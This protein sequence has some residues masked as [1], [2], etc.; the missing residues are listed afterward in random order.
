MDKPIETGRCDGEL[1]RRATDGLEAPSLGR[2]EQML[3]TALRGPAAAEPAGAPTCVDRYEIRGL[4]G[5]GAASAVFRARDPLLDRDVALKLL[6]SVLFLGGSFQARFAREARIVAQLRHTHIVTV[7]DT[8]VLE[9]RPWLVMDLIEGTTLDEQ[10]GK[11]PRLPTDFRRIGLLILKVAEALHFAHLRGVVHRDVKPAN[12]LI[13]ARGEPQ[14]TDFGLAGSWELPTCAGSSSGLAPFTPGAGEASFSRLPGA[15]PN[16]SH[17]ERLTLTGQILGTPQ[18][19]SPEQADCRPHAVDARSDVFSLGVVTYELLT[20]QPPFAGDR[21]SLPRAIREADPVHPA[22]LNAVVPWD[23]TAIC[24]KALAKDPAERY[25]TAQA[26]ADEIRLWLDDRPL[27][28]TPTSRCERARRW[29]RRNLRF[30]N[31]G[32]AAAC[33]FVASLT[34]LGIAYLRHRDAKSAAMAREELSVRALI[35][36]SRDLLG[37]PVAG[38]VDLVSREL[39][40]RLVGHRRKLAGPV[41]VA[42]LDRDIRSLLPDLFSNTDLYSVAKITLRNSTP[43]VAWPAVLHPSGQS[44]AI[45]A[46]DRPYRIEPASGTFDLPLGAE[47]RVPLPRLSYCPGGRW[48]AFAPA[49]GGIELWDESVVE[50]LAARPAAEV[51]VVLAIGFSVD[52]QETR[53]PGRAP[54][55]ARSAKC[56]QLCCRD[57]TWRKFDV[58]NLDGDAQ[59][60]L[61]LE[62]WSEG[63][64]AAAFDRTGDRLAVG[65]ANG[66]IRVYD[67]AGRIGRQF[68]AGSDAIQALAWSADGKKIGAGT[69]GGVL[70]IHDGGSGDVEYRFLCAP[71]GVSHIAFSPDGRCV[72][73]GDRGMD[74]KV[75]ELPTG[76]LVVESDSTPVAFAEDS[77]RLL[78]ANS[79]QIAFWD[80]Y[81][82]QTV[83]RLTGHESAVD[84]LVWS[85]D[86][87]RFATLDSRFKLRIWDSESGRCVRSYS[88]PA[89]DN[90]SHN[91]GLALNR[92]GS[93]VALA[94]SSDR[95]GIMHVL[96]VLGDSSESWS[97]PHGYDRLAHLGEGRFLSVREENGAWNKGAV[98]TVI[99]EFAKGR[100]SRELVL[101]EAE[102]GGDGF[103]HQSITPDGR[104]Y[105]WV[106]PRFPTESRHAE[107]WDL[108]THRRILKIGRNQPADQWGEPGVLISDAGRELWFHQDGSN[109]HPRFF[110]DLANGGAPRAEHRSRAP[111]AVSP[112]GRWVIEA[113]QDGG[114]ER[115]WGFH[116]VNRGSAID[117]VR[118]TNADR[119]YA[120][121]GAMRFSPDA[122]Y[123]A[124]GS[125]T[126]PLTLVDLPEF[127]RRVRQFESQYPPATA[128]PPR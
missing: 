114:S 80:L 11:L 82:G 36:E 1:T 123:L 69:K 57:G 61:P 86:G 76:R 128:T 90:Y 124:W 122:R 102:P 52:G 95:R 71:N 101:R 74:G 103:I 24:L 20:G 85:D 66:T 92:D 68:G 53:Q 18:Y 2:V 97:L 50:R 118:F 55:L 6:D 38:R 10:K 67:R 88:F 121:S 42:S 65:G 81:G 34:S 93:R 5:E 98:R 94:Y 64:S 25:E 109:N 32:L 28:L 63:A 73:A 117:W 96:D 100:Q 89:G 15:F 29:Y 113:E 83:R 9:G 107:L 33:L 79:A 37:L 120:P 12:I 13:D 19:M 51:P 45:G 127:E 75:W 104:F 106:G 70:W 27:R 21:E 84:L 111:H 112:D 44:G 91:A 78:A 126:G 72:A 47:N 17:G 39:L 115:F 125:L 3:R 49:V 46:S 87:S 7:H 77:R 43:N 116:L 56:L 23:L 58:P 59:A 4:L 48:L 41:D 16:F 62:G 14:L 54:P 108:V 60:H 40:P 99:R 26:M 105:V 8:G 30:A 22:R 35:G 119:G 31:L 110:F